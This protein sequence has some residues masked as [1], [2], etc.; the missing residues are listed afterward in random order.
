M[1]EPGSALD[2]RIEL[3]GVLGQGGMGEVHRAW[4]RALERAVAVKFF[5]GTSPREAERL[6]LEGR[7]Q[8]RVD[9][10][11]V[12]RVFDA[13]ELGGRP[14][15]VLQLVE[16]R[17]LEA[18]APELS[19][20]ARVE[21]VRQAALGVH[22]AHLQ[23]LIH[24]DVKPGNV[25]V[26]QGPGAPRALVSDFGLARGDEPGLTRSGAAAGTMA[27]MSPEQLVG[28]P[29]GFAADVYG[30]GATLYAALCG[31]SP[32]AWS[33]TSAGIDGL[34]SDFYS[35]VLEAPPPPLPR[36]VPAPLA[37]VVAKAME[38]QPGARY[39]SA[40]AFAA[41]LARFQKG[42]PVD[43]RPPS[44][45]ERALTW[46][47]R[48]RAFARAMMVAAAALLLSLGW[49]AWSRRQADLEA[50]E[51]ARLGAL[52]ESMEAELRM[53]Y[54]MPAHDV[55]PAL[56]K[57]RA[58]VE[59]LRAQAAR[60]GGAA[61]FA[62]GKGLELLGD[63]EGA[64]AAYERAWAKGFHS[65]R[66]AEGLGN[67]LGEQY[68]QAH[69][70]ALETLEPSARE[71]RLAV[72]RAELRDPAIRYLTLAEAGGW[73]PAFLQA[74]IALLEGDFPTA[75]A[76]AADVL[77][78]GPSRYEALVLQAEAFTEEADQLAEGGRSDEAVE[79]SRRAGALVEEAARFGRSDPRV[80]RA[81]LRAEFR[82]LKQVSMKGQ[83]LQALL[84][85]IAK[86]VEVA[87]GLDP[88][89]PSVLSLQGK[90]LLASAGFTSRSLEEEIQ[91]AD[92]AA[93]L[94]RR[95]AELNGGEASTLSE[96]S[97]ALYLKAF[98][99][100]QRG[101]GSLAQVEE[102]LEVTQRATERAAWDPRPFFVRAWL[103]G[104]E[105]EVLASLKKP[106]GPSLRRAA[107]SAEE[108]LRRGIRDVGSVRRSLGE[109]RIRLADEAWADGKDPRP[110]LEG[111]VAILD[112][113]HQS[114]PGNV[115]LARA[116]AFGHG[117]AGVML[118]GMGA[119]WR[120]HVERAI[121]ILEASL[122]QSPEFSDLEGSVAEAWTVLASQ[123]AR[124]GEDP[125]A[126][127]AQ[128]ARHFQAIRGKR[129]GNARFEVEEAALPM[130]E[131]QWMRSQGMD[132][133]SLVARVERA[134]ARFV[135][136]HPGDPGNA[137]EALVSCALERALLARQQGRDPG[138]P[139]R[140]GVAMLA[141]AL[142]KEP[143]VP[144][145]WA[146]LARLH[147][148]AGDRI[149]AR[150]SLERAWAINPLSRGAVDSRLAEAE[151]GATAKAP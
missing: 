2:G 123:Q 85:S 80:A 118:F 37:R 139:A 45:A 26:E 75:R 44:W 135:R 63:V 143:R 62:L 91:V 34:P 107:E 48:N 69:R 79:A 53:E 59:A 14:C 129:A 93:A 111:A 51:A 73:R 41:D 115:T 120:P 131:A 112:Q 40:E 67:A 5:H 50:L 29:V 98:F 43:A 57:V 18:L 147:L 56:A 78:A 21:L 11:H 60:G 3:K 42:E 12:V 74:S 140:E 66:V 97:N 99:S 103:F 65:P 6:L 96:L 70:R 82:H 92:E 1:S 24:R 20:E 102:A 7:L 83:P 32:H 114:Q 58:Q 142:E 95:A 39:E 81:R 126:A 106:R 25:L 144:E 109:A 151:L 113:A 16:G 101:A 90:S 76:R 10:L 84:A 30:L 104:L 31:R 87:K 4:D 13:G 150:E 133:T 146:V 149:A 46:R 137:P 121:A 141:R 36:E 55:R 88:E 124:S 125:R 17:S 119:D 108:A 28:G 132:S 23:G 54:L 15:L 100:F 27:F 61:S 35:R 138:P 134:M 38:K 9:H 117:N 71:A 86:S 127:V 145:S 33:P 64:R 148:A 19:L 49:T 110:E 130:F 72:L 122:R 136:D 105:A 22:A 128:A 68:R 116:A 8:A 52:G 77:A 89:D 47:R 94:F